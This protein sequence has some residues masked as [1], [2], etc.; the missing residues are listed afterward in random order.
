MMFLVQTTVLDQSMRIEETVSGARNLKKLCKY[1]VS[2]KCKHGVKGVGCSYDHPKKCL[3]F[4]SYGDKSSRGCKKGKKCSFYHPPLCYNAM[5]E[6]YCSRESCKYHHVKG[7]RFG[8]DEIQ[9]DPHIN[10]NN[11]DVCVNNG[12]NAEMP[13]RQFISDRRTQDSYAQRVGIR[14][15]GKVSGMASTQSPTQ[16]S[17]NDNT[18]QCF[19]E[20]MK[21]IQEMQLQIQ[22]MLVHRQP[23]PVMKGCHHCQDQKH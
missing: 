11:N 21:Q 20:I 12:N 13:P 19:L 22:T 6:G 8:W 16:A 3:K 7:T 17:G 15:H 9:R 18:S 23:L 10:N 5:N 14:N 1:Y 2:R 4:V